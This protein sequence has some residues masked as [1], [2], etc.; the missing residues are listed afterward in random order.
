MGRAIVVVHKHLL[1]AD[2]PRSLTV[3]E[4]QWLLDNCLEPFAT[5]DPP[6]WPPGAYFKSL[7]GCS[8]NYILKLEAA[9]LMPVPGKH[10]R[11][12]VREVA[13]IPKRFEQTVYHGTS[14]GALCGIMGIGFRPS[15]GA[16]PDEAGKQ[17][18]CSLPMVYTSALLETAAGYVGNERSGQRIG[19]GPGVN[20]VIWLLSLIHI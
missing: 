7:L 3:A 11:L 19:E 5:A 2:M 14:L 20:W 4:V 17:Y 8:M 18:N 13:D 15:L 10:L 6:P 12:T 9:Y 16:G 1:A